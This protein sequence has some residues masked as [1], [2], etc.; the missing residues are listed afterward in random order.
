[1]HNSVVLADFSIRRL[2][3]NRCGVHFLVSGQQYL[4][5]DINNLVW[6]QCLADICLNDQN[7]VVVGGLSLFD[8][9]WPEGKNLEREKINYS[10]PIYLAFFYIATN[11]KGVFI[12]RITKIFW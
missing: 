1:M 10:L 8:E 11:L 3:G 4:V 12:I 6:I 7:V 9:V 2:M 5:E